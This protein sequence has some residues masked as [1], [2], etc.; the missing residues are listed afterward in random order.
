MA[1]EAQHPPEGNAFTFGGAVEAAK[2]YNHK[3]ATAS[4][5]IAGYAVLNLFAEYQPPGVEG[6]VIR[7]EVNNLF[8]RTYADRATYG[9]DFNSI[10]PLYE[11]GRSVQL[12]A[13]MRF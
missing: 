10:T 2:A 12:V 1:I 13:S 6:L 7:A 5:T 9:Q 3:D 4:K 8:D 11:P